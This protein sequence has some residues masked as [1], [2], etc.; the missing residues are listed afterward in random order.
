M[1]LPSK[2]LV[3]AGKAAATA[4]QKAAQANKKWVEA[5]EAEY[6][7]TDISDALVE[8]VDYGGDASVLTPE[9]IAEHSGQGAS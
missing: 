1:Q 9:F 3:R 2:A 5:F 6:G 8:V 7:H 4:A